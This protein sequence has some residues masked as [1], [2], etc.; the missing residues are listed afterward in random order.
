MRSCYPDTCVRY[1][2]V[3]HTTLPTYPVTSDPPHRC[4]VVRCTFCKAEEKSDRPIEPGRQSSTLP[5]RCAQGSDR[6]SSPSPTDATPRTG[7]L[8]AVQAWSTG[9]SPLAHPIAPG[10]AI[11]AWGKHR[12]AA[13]H[14]EL[15]LLLAN[16][17]GA[18]AAAASCKQLALSRFVASCATVTAHHSLLLHDSR[19][20]CHC[21]SCHAPGGLPHAGLGA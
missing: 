14:G 9:A 4:F 10:L 2:T 20:Y 18:E 6:K 21:L 8:C 15:R 11:G 17:T 12:Q 19:R 3:Q 16:G 5:D 13:R 7:A 1:G